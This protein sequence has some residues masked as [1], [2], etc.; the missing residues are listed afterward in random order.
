M[1]VRAQRL[2]VRGISPWL[3]LAGPAFAVSI[4]YIDPGNWAT[5]LAA[6]SFGLRL[7]WVVVAANAMAIVLQLAVVRLTALCGTD[8]G[9]MIARAAPRLRLAFWCTFQF[10]AIATDLAEF[11]GITLGLLLLLHWPLPVC[12]FVGAGIVVLAFSNAQRRSRLLEGLLIATVGIIALAFAY[13][14]WFLHPSAG[15][16][17]RGLIPTVPSYAALI[18]VV[19]IIGATVM[20]HN[21]FLH[22]SMVHERSGAFPLD[23]RLKRATFYGKET[24]LALNMA[25]FINGGILVVGALLVHANGSVQDAFGAWM[26]DGAPIAATLFGAALLATGIAASV[27]ATMSGDYIFRSFSR[28][29]VPA[30][31]RR[32][33]TLAPA[34]VALLCG[35]NATD[36]LIWSQVA[37]SIILPVALVPM[38]LH[39]RSAHKERGLTLRHALYPAAWAATLICI[40]FDVVLLYQA[41]A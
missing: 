17:A 14:L 3:Q 8:L 13:Q 33:I 37:L 28:R 31:L 10:A 40:A 30:A 29:R 9:T 7:L 23:E 38:M 27:T 41:I 1:N 18:V 39:Y 20:P 26:R 34:A 6:G 36:L 24:V 15:A 22:S 16:V 19:G 32:G 2:H 12:V 25:T 5:D 4:G 35:A 11:T 21:L